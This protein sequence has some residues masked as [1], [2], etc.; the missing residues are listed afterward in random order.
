M[1]GHGSGQRVSSRLWAAASAAGCTAGLKAAER[2]RATEMLSGTAATPPKPLPSGGRWRRC[3]A[4]A[5]ISSGRC[6]TCRPV[7][8]TQNNQ[9]ATQ[10]RRAA[11]ER[12]LRL[13]ASSRLQKITSSKSFLIF[14]HRASRLPKCKRHSAW[15]SI[16]LTLTKIFRATQIPM[17]LGWPF[18]RR[19]GHMPYTKS[20]LKAKGNI[21]TE[22]NSDMMEAMKDKLFDEWPDI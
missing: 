12:D 19:L 1:P 3:F 7:A 14:V 18:A 17:W 9:L 16:I 5:G 4:P 2:P 8:I 21:P 6:A 10:C 13:F 11:D 22:M 20:K 15:G